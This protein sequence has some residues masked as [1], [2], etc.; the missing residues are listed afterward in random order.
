MV[1]GEFPR[2]VRW[3]IVP[4]LDHANAYYPMCAVCPWTDTTIYD[5]VTATNALL[6]H[7][8]T[9][10]HRYWEDEFRAGRAAR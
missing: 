7:L 1:T 6:D 2:R 4:Y 9:D 8:A 3:G 5:A 10:E